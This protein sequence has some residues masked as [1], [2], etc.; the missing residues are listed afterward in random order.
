MASKA[1]IYCIY[2]I[3]EQSCNLYLHD[4]IN[5]EFTTKPDVLDVFVPSTRVSWLE[6]SFSK[7]SGTRS[8]L[9]RA[10]GDARLA[11]NLQR[12]RPMASF[13]ARPPKP[14]PCVLM[15]TVACLGCEVKLI[16]STIEV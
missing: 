4:A 9:F 6:S 7:L 14:V 12:S 16:Q 3:N 15:T 11:S 10:F 13:A 5:F 8:K 1:C 2:A